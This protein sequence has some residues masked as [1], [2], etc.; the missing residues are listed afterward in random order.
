MTHKDHSLEWYYFGMA[1][2]HLISLLQQVE[3]LLQPS[4]STDYHV[5]MKRAEPKLHF[6]W[7]ALHMVVSSF[8]FTL[9]HN[10]KEMVQL[11]Q[12]YSD[13]SMLH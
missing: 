7:H 9:H 1:W 12:R 3:Q 11:L 5:V 2:H 4:A 13:P 8:S 6:C 10:E